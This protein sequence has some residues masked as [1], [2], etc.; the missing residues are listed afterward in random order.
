M[1]NNFS[2]RLSE[3]DCGFMPA[4]KFL[5]S[6]ADSRL[7]LA[8][9]QLH[10]FAAHNITIAHVWRSF[11]DVLD[12]HKAIV[13]RGIN[14]ELSDRTST[15][16][17]CHREL[18]YRIAE[19]LDACLK[20]AQAVADKGLGR[21]EK[22]FKEFA[23]RHK[24]IRDH[25]ALVAN[26]LKHNFC[27]LQAVR[28]T[29]GMLHVFGYFL[30]APQEDGCIAPHEEVH[31][32]WKDKE[33]AISFNRDLRRLFVEL[34]EAATNLAGYLHALGIGPSAPPAQMADNIMAIAGRIQAIPAYCFPDE[35][36]RPSPRVAV[37]ESEAGKMLHIESHSKRFP[38][39]EPWGND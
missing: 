27:P 23:D 32:R 14:K 17:N 29:N 6:L 22:N 16:L 25:A 34:F 12:A 24:D 38:M 33:T 10:P 21:K 30:S 19:H 2:L 39:M 35:A 31:P 11:A 7:S 8:K 28:M 5:G 18:L 26:T 20:A 15:L 4:A 36:M 37:E 3:K 1:L 13:P 9:G